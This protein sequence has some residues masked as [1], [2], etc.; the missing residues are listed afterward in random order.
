[1]LD[2]KKHLPAIE[3]IC[4]RY[5]VKRLSIFGSA[6]TDRFG[7]KSDVDLIVEYDREK[8]V[9]WARAYFD[10][11]R[12]FEQYFRRPV[13]LMTDKPIRNSYLRRQVEQT[14]KLIYER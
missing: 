2:L 9:S 7:P 11:A 1:M 10:L 13:D 5:P 4:R 8:V 3:E 6:L 14:K 12:D